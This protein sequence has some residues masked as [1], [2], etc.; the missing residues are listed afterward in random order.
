MDLLGTVHKNLHGMYLQVLRVVLT[1]EALQFLK[2]FLRFFMGCD[3][4]TAVY[5]NRQLALLIQITQT[6]VDLLMKLGK[7][8][9]TGVK[10]SANTCIYR[11]LYPPVKRRINLLI[12]QPHGTVKDNRNFRGCF[13]HISG[14]MTILSYIIAKARHGIRRIIVNSVLCKDLRVYPYAVSLSFLD[15][16]LRIRTDRI[17][18]LLYDIFAV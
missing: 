16:K 15:Q 18:I 13:I 4:I 17:Q 10:Y 9:K 14:H 12:G 11:K 1:T 3:H 7:S 2:G 6:F 5:I 8:G